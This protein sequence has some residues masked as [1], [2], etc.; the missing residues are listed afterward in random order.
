MYNRLE[1]RLNA[2]ESRVA[3]FSMPIAH[4]IALKWLEKRT[5]FEGGTHTHEIG[6]IRIAD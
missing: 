2:S 6:K 5:I 4:S 1:D 3:D